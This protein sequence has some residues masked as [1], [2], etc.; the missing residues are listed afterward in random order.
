MLTGRTL[1][2]GTPPPRADE[3]H[4]LIFLQIKIKLN[5]QINLHTVV[6]H[7]SV[8]VFLAHE[9]QQLNIETV[10]ANINEYV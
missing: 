10:F 4:E 5:M 9:C 7:Y 1:H 8:A 3:T 2:E 6:P